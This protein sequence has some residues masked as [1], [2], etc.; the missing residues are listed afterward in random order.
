MELFKKVIP[1]KKQTEIINTTNHVKVYKEGTGTS[2]I[3]RFIFTDTKGGR[4]AITNLKQIKHP[5]ILAIIKSREGVNDI[6]IKSILLFPISDFINESVPY[7]HYVI[8]ILSDVIS[9]LKRCNLTHNGIMV[10]NFYCNNDGKFILAGF[11]RSMTEE[12]INDDL[13]FY[14][15][16]R[17]WEVNVKNKEYPVKID[18]K[19]K[20]KKN[21]TDVTENDNAVS[22]VEIDFKKITDRNTI[23]SI[24]EK[25]RNYQKIE[26]FI[27]INKDHQKNNIYTKLEHSFIKFKLMSLSNK[28][29]LLDFIIQQRVEWIEPVKNLIIKFF[30][31]EITTK[32]YNYKTKIL[33]M[34][35]SLNI[36]NYDLFIEKLFSQPDS[37]VRLF[38]LQNLD[39]YKEKITVWNNKLFE[40]LIVGLKCNDFALQFESIKYINKISTKLNERNVKET[41]KTLQYG[42]TSEMIIDEGIYF[43]DDN[44]KRIKKS[45]VLFKEVYKII[46]IF[47]NNDA[48]RGNVIDLLSRMYDCFD[49]KKLQG[50]VLPALCNYL[51]DEIVQDLCFDVISEILGFLKV[52][53]KEIVRTEWSVKTLGN[54]INKVNFKIPTY[55]S[56]PSM[57]ENTKK[58]DK[59]DWTDNW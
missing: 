36:P 42:S 54:L 52:H 5:N 43:I 23:M 4:N 8:S 2:A 12:S 41:I 3:T 14:D 21:P 48:R 15:I 13:M 49:C 17:E 45:S 6:C 47:M 57:D 27:D 19:F 20:I 7:L 44:I 16:L 32:N 25:C 29:D 30:I 38:L 10:E 59:N 37:V 9:F 31:A 34:L 56:K 24:M 46:F 22:N 55:N 33:I 11:E 26:D 53:K 40:N 58:D 1:F 28:I 35:F 51:S 50:E 39:F 18:F